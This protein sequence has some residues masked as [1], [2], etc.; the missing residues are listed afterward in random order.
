MLALVALITTGVDAGLVGFVLSYAL[1]TT[2]SLVRRTHVFVKPADLPSVHNA[3]LVGALRKRS[4]DEHRQCRAYF[5]L[6]WS[7]AG[8][9]SRDS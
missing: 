7:R 3:E 8:G 9:S 1:N 2:G 5:A 4:R 6:H